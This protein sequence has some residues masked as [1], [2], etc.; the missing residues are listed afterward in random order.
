MAQAPDAWDY[1]ASDIPSPLTDELEAAQQSKKVGWRRGRVP[2]FA[3]LL[4]DWWHPMLGFGLRSQH[5][6][7]SS[8]LPAVA[9]AGYSCLLLARGIGVVTLPLCVL[10]A[11]KRARQRAKEKERKEGKQAAASPGAATPGSSSGK[12]PAAAAAGGAVDSFDAELA[13]AMAEAAAISSRWVEGGGLPKLLLQLPSTRSSHVT[14][15]EH[16]LVKH[17]HLRPVFAGM[18]DS[19]QQP[20]WLMA[21]VGGQMTCPALAALLC[22]SAAALHNPPCCVPCVRA[23]PQLL[24]ASPSRWVVLAAAANGVAA[25]L[26][27]LL[28]LPAPPVLRR[29][30]AGGSSWQQQQRHDSRLCSRS[31]SSG[32][33]HWAL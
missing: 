29:W 18:H 9:A 13:A 6:C 11:D 30:R 15:S 27:L 17:R 12:G 33:W 32:Q 4:F 20:V 10:Q 7:L 8:I 3:L 19:T 16:K 2:V 28:L 5:A 14:L 23:G 1:A 31:S 24:P 26:R 25:G 21:P 22:C